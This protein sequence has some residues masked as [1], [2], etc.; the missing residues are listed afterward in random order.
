MNENIS[1][2]YIVNKIEHFSTSDAAWY[3]LYDLTRGILK[4]YYEKH[5]DTYI[6][7][8]LDRVLKDVS[9]RLREIIAEKKH[10]GEPYHFEIDN[11]E[12]AYIRFFNSMEDATI[13]S[14]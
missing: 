1:I 8:E 11:E 13:T 2:S 9:N 3:S 7:E 4:E 10:S 12:P 6:S 5:S 14:A